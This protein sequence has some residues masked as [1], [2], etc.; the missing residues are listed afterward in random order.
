MFT[1]E[2]R[3]KAVKLLIQYDMS[4]A[5]VIHELEYP[6]RRASRNWYEVYLQEGDLHQGYVK[7]TKFSEEEI[8][9]AVNY[10][11]EHGK[12]ESRTAKKLGYPSRPVLDKWILEIAPN[13]NRHYQRL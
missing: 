12:N 6:S 11:L 9:V 1:Y 5:T 8:K 10:Y 7:K 2:E 3:I 13:E 4:Y